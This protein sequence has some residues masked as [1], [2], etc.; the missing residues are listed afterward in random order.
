MA[1]K[2][3]KMQI[4]QGA[5]SCCPRA[6]LISFACCVSA[7]ALQQPRQASP[8]RV[9]EYSQTCLF[10]RALWKVV[11]QT[12]KCRDG[13]PRPS[14]AKRVNAPPCR[15]SVPTPPNASAQEIFVSGSWNEREDQDNASAIR[16]SFMHR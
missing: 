9:G 3:P 5:H 14:R 6:Q 7:P 16:T 2:R 11:K 4:P 8:E 13:R 12:S 1:L 10:Y 15:K